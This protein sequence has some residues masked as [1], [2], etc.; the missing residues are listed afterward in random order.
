MYYVH[1]ELIFVSLKNIILYKTTGTVLLCIVFVAF[2]EHE[3]F[4]LNICVYFNF[5]TPTY[6]CNNE[7]KNELTLE[8]SSN[9]EYDTKIENLYLL[10]K[11]IIIL[12]KSSIFI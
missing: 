1:V 5:Y 6:T 7:K 11:T 9:P 3:F 4:L 10:I 8:F 2:I 12:I